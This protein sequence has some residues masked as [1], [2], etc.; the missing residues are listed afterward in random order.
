MLAVGF[1]DVV[2]ATHVGMGDL[3]R[4]AHFLVESR[5][6]V[7]IARH[8]FRQEFERD[9]CPSLGSSARDASSYSS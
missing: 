1:A 6:A 4:D 8:V 5:K 9:R 2:D 7:G 3:A